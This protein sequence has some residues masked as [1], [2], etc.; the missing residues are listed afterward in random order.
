MQ[1]SLDLVI[2]HDLGVGPASI[3][4]SRY[5]LKW[6]TSLPRFQLISLITFRPVA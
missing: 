6:L 5:L 2:Q 3:D 4:M 1:Y